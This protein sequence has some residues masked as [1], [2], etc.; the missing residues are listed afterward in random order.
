VHE[1]RLSSTVEPI[2][3]KKSD[4]LHREGIEG[5]M[6]TILIAALAN[7]P[8]LAE[9]GKQKQHDSTKDGDLFVGP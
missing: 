1:S 4:A 8:L 5:T 2:H 9:G 3:P 7:A 6:R